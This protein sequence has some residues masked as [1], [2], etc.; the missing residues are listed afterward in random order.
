MK[1]LFDRTP[2]AA[3][4]KPEH[5]EATDGKLPFKTS[6]CLQ[7]NFKIFCLNEKQ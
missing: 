1:A 3:A 5:V 6:L 7:K 4:P 2:T